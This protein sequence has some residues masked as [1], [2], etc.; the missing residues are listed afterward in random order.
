MTIAAPAGPAA[1]A[2]PDA[3]E[4]VDRARALQPLI[5]AHA[6]RNAAEGRIAPEVIA[7][8]AAAG[9][10]RVLQP[11]R[12]GGYE[13]PPNIFLDIQFELARADMSTGWVYGVLACHNFQMGL[14]DDRAQQDVWGVDDGA[15]IA[16]TFQ[17]GGI[18]RPVS[19]GYAFD[20]RWKFASGCDHADWIFLGGS[21]DGE[22]LTCLLPRDQYAIADAWNVSGLKGTG[23]KDIVVRDVVIPEWRVHKS[24]D[25]F[26]CDSP[27]NRVNRG[28]LYRMPFHQIFIRA[29]TGSAIGA[30]QG[31]IDAFGAYA[32]KRVSVV[33]GAT[34]RDPDALLALGEA[35]VAVDELRAIAERNC[36]SLEHWA[37]QGVPP[38]F[39]MR[40]RY[41]YQASAVADRCVGA[42]RAL[43]EN[44][45]GTGLYD[46]HPFGR[47]LNDLVA[48]RQHAAA[49]YR[50]AGRSLGALS[51]GQEV[52]EWYL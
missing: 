16:S 22:F 48:A 33:A 52:N 12:R 7:A 34:V 45:G 13:M 8:I 10:L 26:R 9:L 5:R 18:A 39:D 46:D 44:V 30:L 41:K 32:Q 47:I 29:I 23:S 19:G 27:G 2:V 14:F 42:A 35:I 6:A 37:R 1:D 38:P 11:A 50:L 3:A 24:S 40:L 36:A 17:P 28:W 21:L 15:R 49:Q 43:F 51:L 20:G 25:G 31:M 4:L